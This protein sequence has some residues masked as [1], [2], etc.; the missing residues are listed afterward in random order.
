MSLK[1][2]IKKESVEALKKGDS[3]RVEILRFLISLLDKKGLLLPPGK[4]TD[5]DG[6]AVL[7]KELKN[8]QEARDMFTK[9]GRKDLVK[10]ADTEI[11]VV[12]KY[13]PVQMGEADVEKIVD[14]VMGG[15]EGKNFGQIM[16]G[17]MAKVGGEA[18]GSLVAKMVKAKISE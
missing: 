14:E 12:E 8:K 3:R 17:V 1:D 15:M 18:D 9:A 10:E 2:K 11:A 6:V 4:M 7:R 5:V 13:L 16:N